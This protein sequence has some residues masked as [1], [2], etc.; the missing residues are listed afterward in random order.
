MNSELKSLVFELWM[1]AK[2]TANAMR[3]HD[4]CMAAQEEMF[5]I[6]CALERIMKNTKDIPT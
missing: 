2:E 4:S 1:K 6:I 3:E 5:L